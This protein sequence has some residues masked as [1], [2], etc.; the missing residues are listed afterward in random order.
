MRLWHG[1]ALFHLGEYS[2]AIEVYEKMLK[3]DP[4]DTTVNLYIASCHFYNRDYEEARSAALRG[5]QCDFRTRLVFHI[6]HQTND[7]QELFQ[8]HSQLVGTLENQLAL[9]AIHYLRCAYQDAIEIYQR[10]LM[11][12]SEYLAL[13]VY[14]AMCQFKI[15]QFEESNEAVDLYLGSNSDSAV[16]LNLKACDYQKLFDAEIAEAQLLQIKKFSTASYDFMD[17]LISHNLCVFHNGENGFT[18]LPKLVP[19]LSEARFNLAV[20]Y[21]RQN[22]PTEAY[23]LL[24]DMPPTELN[25]SLLKATVLLAVGQLKSDAGPIQ[26]AH[27]LFTEISSV[28]SVRDTV[29][30]RE[31]LASAKFIVGEYDEALRVL[32]TIGGH[33][34][35]LDEFNYDKGMTLVALGRYAEAEHHLLQVKSP[36]YT[37]ELFYQMWLCRCYIN[38]KKPESAWAL[39]VDATTPDDSKTLLN[40]IAADSFSL[41]QYYYAMRA[42]DVLSKYDVD[43]AYRNGLIASAVG[44]FRG[45]L[46]GKESSNKLSEVMSTLAP[47]PEAAEVLHTIQRY[48]MESGGMDYQ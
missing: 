19:L 46:S 18:V 20:L 34:G 37:K 12:N 21:M 3:D 8:A 38:N 28:E 22:N 41:G 16:A 31:A 11:Q 32:E 36:S 1:Y 5:P 27:T 48:A 44:V 33:V 9:A 25:E 15:D 26:Q 35:H 2:A 14:I 29:P 24:Q 42:Y 10:L 6:A 17:A 40:I 45:V 7:E 23:E 47:E 4:E 13:N 39:Y 43:N 30:G